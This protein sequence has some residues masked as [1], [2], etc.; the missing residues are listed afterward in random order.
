MTYRP[1]HLVRF[2]WVPVAA[3]IL[4][5]VAVAALWYYPNPDFPNDERSMASSIAVLVA[6][7]VIA[8]WVLFLSG[9]RWV[10][11]IGILAVA[12]GLVFSL[13]WPHFQG[14][15][16]P[17]FRFRWQH[18]DRGQR[19]TT[20]QVSIPEPTPADFPEYRNRNRDGVITGLKLDR[21]WAIHPP[22]KLWEVSLGDDAGYGGISVVGPAAITLEQIGPMEA[23]VCYD[24]DSGK[25]RWRYEYDALF[26]ELMGGTGP[27]TNPTIVDGD[28][29]T[30]GATG[31]LARLD[32]KTGKPKWTADIV[33]GS[34]VVYWG[35]SGSPLVYDRF[36][37]VNRGRNRAGLSKDSAPGTGPGVVAYDRETGK[38]AWES[39]DRQAGYSSP[40]LA[41]IGGI[42]QVLVFDAD[43]L[44]SFDPETGK[45]LWFH[46][47]TQDPEVNVAQ[48]LV[49]DDGR[50]FISS[51]YGHGCAMLMV[52]NADGKWAVKE[53]WS[54][55]RLKSKFAN[56]V[57]L[58]EHIFGID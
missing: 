49:F 44:G 58:G 42:R 47:W 29:Y 38:V 56:P 36:V 12:A 14:N 19:E 45:E 21:G 8:L 34:N 48:P 31:H 23:V 15:L 28:V 40:Q 9:I 20:D 53:M 50:V 4:A 35:E 5:G 7:L 2:R 18:H 46:E 54:N 17:I 33:A 10:L 55:S 37:V 13:R 25:E 30:L 39:G 51:G 6:A 57:R 1:P 22:E 26:T 11:R 32:G 24:S 3:V 41:T 27:R 16:I 52:T 43:G